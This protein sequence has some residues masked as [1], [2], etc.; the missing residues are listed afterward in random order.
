[1]CHAV[2]VCHKPVFMVSQCHLGVSL[3][4]VS[5]VLTSDVT[6]GDFDLVVT[7]NVFVLR[8]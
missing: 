8:W 3:S 4:S 6:G 2:L 7:R 1:M 5:L